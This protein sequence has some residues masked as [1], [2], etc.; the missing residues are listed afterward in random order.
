MK[1]N[2][3]VVGNEIR[4][5]IPKGE[6]MLVGLF[7]I[8][9]LPRLQALPNS[10]TAT[11][12]GSRSKKTYLEHRQRNGVVPRISLHRYIMDAPEGSIVDHIDRNPLNNKKSNLRF[13]TYAENSV[14][15]ETSSSTGE[16]YI[17][18]N[19]RGKFRF[20]IYKNRKPIVY[21][22]SSNI[23]ELVQFRNEWLKTHG[24]QYGLNVRW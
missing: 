7:D 23:K 21:K 4:V 11:R 6:E 16:H 14:N 22:E 5:Y 13:V 12:G 24:S 18:D 17:Y 3:E 2:F 10:I 19:K 20:A 15:V 1:N 9:D 8:D